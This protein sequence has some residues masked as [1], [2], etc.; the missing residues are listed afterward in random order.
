MNIGKVIGT[1]VS[2]QKDPKFS[3][4]KLLLVQP[5]QAKTGGLATGGS[6]VVAVDCVGSGQGEWVMYTQGSSARQTE[7]TKNVPTDAVIV[8]IVDTLEIE[9]KKV[10]RP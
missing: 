10:E 7:C 1:V 2:S 6:A 3:G 4:L 9:G 8:G 5:Y